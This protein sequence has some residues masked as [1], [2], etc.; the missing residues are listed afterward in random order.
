VLD[1]LK[2]A[3]LRSRRLGEVPGKGGLPWTELTSD[4]FV[5]WTDASTEDGR[6]LIRV[7]ETLRQIPRDHVKRQ[8]PSRKSRNMRRMVDLSPRRSANPLV[9]R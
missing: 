8:R 7:M 9:A 4:H 2:D 6:K 1:D 5:V 3:S